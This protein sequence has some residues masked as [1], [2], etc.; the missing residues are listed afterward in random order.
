MNISPLKNDNKL[1]LLSSKAIVTY[2]KVHINLI[3]VPSK[4]NY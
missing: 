1:F 2:F 4:Y 3:S